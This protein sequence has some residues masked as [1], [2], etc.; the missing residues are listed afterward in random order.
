MYFK[1]IFP[2][3]DVLIMQQQTLEP[4]TILSLFN[5]DKTF[6]KC[7][8]GTWLLY[9]YTYTNIQILIDVNLLK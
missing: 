7:R 4:K 5:F 1:M 8:T 6:L 9:K 2:E 3:L